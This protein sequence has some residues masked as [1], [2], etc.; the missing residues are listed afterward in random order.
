MKLAAAGIGQ[1]FEFFNALAQFV[2]YGSTAFE[3]GP[4]IDRWLDTL[5][6]PIEKAE[7]DSMLNIG[8]GLRNRRLRDR[9]VGSRL[10]HAARSRDGE[11]DVQV[12]NLRRRPT[13]SDHCMRSSLNGYGMVKQ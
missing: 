10:S 13:R 1:E 6:S 3:Q 11:Q 8:N 12:R 9:K 5:R 4:T 2:E 7:A